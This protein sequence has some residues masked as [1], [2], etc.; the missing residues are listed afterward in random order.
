M[1]AIILS[2]GLVMHAEQ[3]ERKAGAGRPQLE[4]K[5]REVAFHSEQA[6]GALRELERRLEGSR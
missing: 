1:A 3:S 2:C 6:A 4:L 5:T